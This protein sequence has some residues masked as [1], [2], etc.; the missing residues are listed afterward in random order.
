MTKHYFH[1][2][3]LL[4]ATVATACGPDT[5]SKPDGDDEPANQGTNGGESNNGS[6]NNAPT[7]NNATNGANNVATNNGTTSN[8]GGTNPGGMNNPTT[9][10]A[11]TNNTSA[12]NG[13]TNNTPTNNTSTNNGTNNPSTNNGTNNGTTGCVVNSQFFGQ[14][15]ATSPHGGGSV[16]TTPLTVDAGLR[17]VLDSVPLEP[18]D[19]ATDV[20][21]G[22]AVLPAPLPVSGAIVIAT[23]FGT[24][25]DTRFW[26]QDKEVAIEAHLNPLFPPTTGLRVGDEVSFQAVAVRNFEGQPQIDALQNFVILSRD[27]GVPVRNIGA[28]NVEV[29]DYAHIVRVAGVTGASY[30]C[31][32]V[33]TCF[34]FQHEGG[35]SIYRTSS[36][37]AQ[38]GDCVTFVGPAYAFP[39]P[40]QSAETPTMQLDVINYDW[41]HVE[42]P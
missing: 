39:G 24:R 23:G 41:V 40:R 17:S 25:G 16:R 12:N 28:R 33:S 2:S 31:G 8:D 30:P 6:S 9:N 26:L 14:I 37:F 15:G 32:G 34:E 20:D 10:N 29:G 38:T 4:A 18:D 5:R 36:D 19:P 35:Q 1:L 21:E 22:Y 42:I 27:N 3:L 13:G 7:E 11:S